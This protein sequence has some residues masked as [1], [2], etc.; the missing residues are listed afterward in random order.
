LKS[1]FG[2]HNPFIHTKVI[3]LWSSGSDWASAL[4]EESRA[5]ESAKGL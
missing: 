4:A 1:M 3:I 5:K 2:L